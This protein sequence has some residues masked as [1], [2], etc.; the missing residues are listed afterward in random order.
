VCEH[1]RVCA[2]SAC[3]IAG[4][5]VEGGRDEEGGTV[6]LIFVFAVLFLL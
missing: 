6:E 5:R 2:P 4:R 1:E 3:A